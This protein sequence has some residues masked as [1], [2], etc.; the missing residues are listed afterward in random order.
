[1]PQPLSDRIAIVDERGNP[2]PY[3]IRMLQENGIDLDGKPDMTQVNAAITAAFADRDINT[4]DGLQGG[5]NLSADRTLSLT[6]TGV[7]PGTYGD[8][9]NSPQI[10]VDEKGRITSVVDVPISGGGGGGG[11]ISWSNGC[12]ERRFLVSATAVGGV[13]NPNFMLGGVGVN[14]FYWNGAGGTH[15]IDL[16]FYSPKIVSGLLVQQDGTSAN[17]IWTISGSNDGVS[18]TPIITDFQWGGTP[19]GPVF[20]P[21]IPLYVREFTNTTAYR[22]YKIDLNSGSGTSSSP[23]CQWMGFKCEA[24]A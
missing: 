14:A 11:T 24:L 2:T 7:T 6:D 21:S 9:T 17:G 23:Y 8:A 12:S 19:Y 10:T 22:Y 1:M 13:G 3:F 16:D 5:G 4:T 18:Y 20:A 15:T